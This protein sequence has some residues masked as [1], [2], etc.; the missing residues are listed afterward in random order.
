M[1]NLIKFLRGSQDNLDLLIKSG[2]ATEGAFYLTHDTDRLYI[3]KTVDGKVIPVSVNQG[4]ITVPTLADLPSPTKAVAGEF[5]YV[6]K[7]KAGEDGKVLNVLCVC[8]GSQWVQVN[9]T[10]DDTQLQAAIEEINE[11]IAAING[12]IEKLQDEKADLTGAEFTGKVYGV[13]PDD[14]DADKLALV[15]RDY[16]D[17]AVSGLTG[18]KYATVEQLNKAVEDIDG[19]ISGINQTLEDK[20]NLA[21]ADFTK[22]SI[23]GKAI[24]TQEYANGVAETKAN[25]AKE[26][27]LGDAE[28]Y[29]DLGAVE[30]KINLLAEADAGLDAK[31]ADYVKI[32]G[33]TDF[34]AVPKV[35]G[36]NVATA[37]DIEDVIEALIGDAATDYNTLGK[38][39]DK[40]I[41]LDGA[42]KA[43]DSG[44]QAQIDK[45]KGSVSDLANVM[46]FVGVTTTPITDGNTTDTIKV[47][48]NDHTA[49]VGDVVIYDGEEFVWDGSAWK[50]FGSASATTA[51]LEA[52]ESQI[53]NNKK[54]Y[55][56]Y[57]TANDKDIA[58][59]K[60]ADSGFTQALTDLGKTVADN[61]T[62]FETYKGTNDKAVSDNTTAIGG[63][64]TTVNGLVTNSATKEELAIETAA[65][66]QLV[67]DLEWG[68]FDPQPAE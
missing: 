38:I 65:R 58:A 62:A 42:Y 55:D 49:D 40:I 57:V 4:I 26:A 1:A 67:K 22:A 30:A 6:E 21:D 61:N 17:E 25:A 8:N 5:Y 39:E 32:D 45:I 29:T 24:A 44:L 2:G 56:D 23:G 34:T 36:V 66:E 18:G 20:A 31:F 50:L 7:D 54:A 60:G 48:N 28:T 52:L 19:D 12:T 11:G 16:V 53:T 47:N 3:G 37:D 64:T 15:T 51:A 68:S 33:T 46:A 10:Y 14:T 59:L 41:A 9:P 27:I 35:N 43:A 13:T 63:L